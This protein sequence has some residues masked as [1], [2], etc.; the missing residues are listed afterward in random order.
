M[1]QNFLKDSVSNYFVYGVQLLLGIVAI[2][3]YIQAFGDSLYGVYLLSLGLAASFL[4]LEFG[5]GKSILR[6]TAEYLADGEEDKYGLALK[7][8]TLITAVTSLATAGIFVGF[9]FLRHKLFNIP[10][11]YDTEAFWLFIGT[12]IY[13]FL[14]LI[15]QL[16]QSMLKGAGIFYLRNKFVLAEL[17]LRGLTIFAVWWWNLSIYFLLGAELV[18]V[19]TAMLFDIVVLVQRV[20]QILRT[21]LLF[22]RRQQPILQGEVFQY[23][24]ETFFLS[25]IGFFSQNS[26][27]LIIGFFLDV[28]FITVYTVI[29]KP[30]AILKSL[31]GKFYVIFSPYYI[32]IMKQG[33]KDALREFLVKFS[34][35]SNL[36]I[37]LCI[38]AGVILLPTLVR[39]WLSTDAYDPYI[40]YGQ[41]LLL[42]YMIRTLAAMFTGALYMTGETKRLIVVEVVSVI[43]NLTVSLLLVNLIGVG[44]VLIGTFVQLLFSVPYIL[45]IS[46]NW[47]EEEAPLYR[48][49]NKLNILFRRYLLNILLPAGILIVSYF[50]ERADIPAAHI[51]T[52]TIFGIGLLIFLG[53]LLLNYRNIKNGATDLRLNFFRKYH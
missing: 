47:L 14:L 19:T 18:I 41:L 15:S 39:W 17:A 26:D 24:K 40:I 51:H 23:A 46:G 33:G 20:P 30:Y 11:E 5:S 53:G 49:D 27:R 10:P 16:S 13:A 4:F 44:G 34:A 7:T 3:V 22:A 48:S 52:L 6:Y 2:P 42:V 29:T 1:K 50:L 43:L 36:I 38:G 21:D 31:L 8:C 35:V 37:G 9:A 28:R 25:V 45:H 32:R 12:A